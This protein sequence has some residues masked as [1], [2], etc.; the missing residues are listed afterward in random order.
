MMPVFLLRLLFGKHRRAAEHLRAHKGA[1]ALVVA[2]SGASAFDG[3]RIAAALAACGRNVL[4]PAAPSGILNKLVGAPYPPGD[5]QNPPP[6]R[7]LIRR[8]R[9][10]PNAAIVVFPDAAN[11]INPKSCGGIVD[12]LMRNIP[13]AKLACAAALPSRLY[14]G[15]VINYAPPESKSARMHYLLRL[16]EDAACA[17]QIKG[18]QN[19]TTMLA[20]AGRH[21][22]FHRRV[23]SQLPGTA[24]T[25]RTLCR[26]AFALGAKLPMPSK[27]NSGRI[28]VMLPSSVAACA[29]FYAAQTRALTPVMLNPSGGGR[30]VMAACRKAKLTTIYT[31]QLLLDKSPQAATL[32][33]AMRAAGMRVILL[34]DLRQTIGIATKLKA[35]AMAL[36]PTLALKTQPGARAKPDDEACILFTSGSESEP[37]G[38]VLSHGNLTANCRQTLA[39][40]ALLPGDRILNTLPVFHSFGL[41]AGVVLPVA[42][43]VEA[44]HYPTPLHYSIIPGVIH[45]RAITIFFSA[46]TFLANYGK[47][48]APEQMQSLR[49]VV[50]GAEKLRESTRRL[51][52]EKFNIGLWEGYGVTETSPVIAFN[53]PGYAKVGTVGIPLPLIQ[54]RLAAAPGVKEGGVL[55]V[56]GPNIMRG[57]LADDKGDNN[58]NGNNATTTKKGERIAAPP[59]G[60]HNT[61]D[62]ATIDDDGYIRIIGRQKRFVK[63]AGEMAA[64]DAIEECLKKQWPDN[65][66]AVVG[67]ASETRGEVAALLTTLPPSVATREN[68]TAALRKQ[69]IPELWTPRRIKTAEQIPQ[70]PTG[71]TNYP[72][73]RQQLTEQ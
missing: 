29:L 20:K 12:A 54:T 37:K 17:G 47:N 61:G 67:I 64:L 46:D 9:A 63:I 40:L 27:D 35:A 41:L 10:L 25:Y 44:M 6:V 38:A 16:M 15:E 19:L 65:H 68:I 58:G 26:A 36:M 33:D 57:Y 52:R 13:G 24:L 50:A 8:A 1:G 22:G 62:I 7:M 48:A 21:Y 49:L 5:E 51:W 59:E 72:A 31:A 56:K 71:K 4:Y 43:G 66:F 30:Q 60:W 11:N 14:F 18:E 45:A 39:R 55:H 42:A 34:E 23:F 73:A 53:R 69:G 28:G 32:A 2:A 70:L 3:F